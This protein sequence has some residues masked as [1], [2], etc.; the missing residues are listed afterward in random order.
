VELEDAKEWKLMRKIQGNE[1]LQAIDLSTVYDRSKQLEN[2]EYFKCLDSMIT[3]YARC[4]RAIKCR[5]AMATA[6]FSKKK[7]LHQQ[8]GF[9]F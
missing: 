9:K 3:N 4:T 2:V 8:S 7:V 6:A 1:N 5:N